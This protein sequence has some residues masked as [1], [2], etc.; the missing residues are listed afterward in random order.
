LC[1]I[2]SVNATQSYYYCSNTET[3]MNIVD[4]T[5][6]FVNFSMNHDLELFELDH[7][8]FKSQLLTLNIENHSKNDDVN[9]VNIQSFKL[10]YNGK[11]PLNNKLKINNKYASKR[12]YN[13]ILMH[14][15]ADIVNYTFNK[16]YEENDPFIREIATNITKDLKDPSRSDITKAVYEWV[17][18]HVQYE[19]PV[20]YESKHY[21]SETARLGKG[22]CCDQARLV[23]AILRAC[24][25]PR[26][27]TLYYHSDSVKMIGGKIIGHVWPVV[28]LENGEELVCDTSSYSSSLGSPAWVNM[29]YIDQH[30][31][32]EY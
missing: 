14:N 3:S 18:G 6:T 4:N 15:N 22:N 24:E 19:K 27:A 10:F 13:D 31:N 17:D 23:I 30:I 9:H 8:G 32:L 2:G 28:I 12:R 25:I 26:N 5:M 21:A 7:M 16:D 20:Y 29:G 11:N 1:I